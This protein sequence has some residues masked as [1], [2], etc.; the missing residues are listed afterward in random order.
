MTAAGVANARE[1]C[2][3][4]NRF[5]IAAVKLE[6]AWRNAKEN[7][8]EEQAKANAEARSEAENRQQE[9]DQAD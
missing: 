1:K 7:A 8:I 6:N 4:L 2:Q 9:S 5:T 3:E